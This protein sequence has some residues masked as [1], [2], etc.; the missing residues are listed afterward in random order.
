M[1]IKAAFRE[2]SKTIH[3]DI[4]GNGHTDG[5]TFT[6]LREAYKILMSAASTSDAE[7]KTSGA[8]YEPGMLAR[9][10]ATHRWRERQGGRA[11][12]SSKR[13]PQW[14]HQC[15]YRERGGQPP[16]TSATESPEW[17]YELEALFP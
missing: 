10:E 16:L 12:K 9:F 14:R 3:P 4:A 1:E 5:R 11:N 7:T 17:R 2:K 8:I 13:T 6:E 15:F